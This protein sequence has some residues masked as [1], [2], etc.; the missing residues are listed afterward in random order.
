MPDDPNCVIAPPVKQPTIHVQASGSKQP[1]PQNRHLVDVQPLG[2]VRGVIPLPQDDAMF[3]WDVAAPAGTN[4]RMLGQLLAATGNLY[5]DETTGH[6][7]V[8]VLPDGTTRRVGKGRQLAPLIVDRVRMQ[9]VKDG[10]LVR[11]LPA[12]EHLNAM[13]YTKAFLEQ[14]LPV[15]E[16]TN[17]FFYARRF[18]PLQPGYNDHGPGSRIVYLR[19]PCEVSEFLD[20]INLFLAAM[21]FASNADRTNAV[22]AALTVRLRREWCGEKP[23]VLITA[24]Q[25]HAGKTTVGDF[26]RSLPIHL[27]PTGDIQ[28]RTSPIGNPRLEFLPRNR[29]RIEAEFNGMIQK[30]LKA[31]SPLDEDVVYP[32]TPWARTIGG[33]LKVNG[34]TDF[35]AN[36]GTRKSNDD[37]IRAALSIL[38]AATPGEALRPREWAKLAVEQG[39]ARTLF[40]VN[41]LHGIVKKGFP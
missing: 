3:L 5:R 39:L 41:E 19:Q 33:I 22:A 27:A 4:Y 28:N 14:F 40:S 11:E 23:L 34:F 6:G 32:M 29:N 38:G 37:P 7:L 36:Y 25:S 8:L 15:D 1:R 20:T 10:K 13:L 30:W 18:Q 9:V 21:P 35:L 12:A 2:D 26:I 24:T 16:V 31:G 17:V